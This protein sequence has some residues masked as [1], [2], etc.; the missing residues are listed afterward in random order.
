MSAAQNLW[1]SWV[2]YAKLHDV[3]RMGYLCCGVYGYTLDSVDVKQKDEEAAELSEQVI[4]Y[5]TETTDAHSGRMA[6]LF[7]DMMEWYPMYFV[8]IDKYT[9]LK[10]AIDHDIGEIAV[11]DVLDDH[12][13]AHEDKKMPEW[14]AIKRQYR[15]LP[16]SSR[17]ALVDCHHQFD[18]SKT[19]LGQS[20][21]LADKLDFLAG[22]IFERSKG[23]YG[24]V[25]LKT[26]VSKYDKLFAEEIGSNDYIDI[27]ARHL[28]QIFRDDQFDSRLQ[29]IAID[30]LTCGLKSIGRP[31]YPW[32]PK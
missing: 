1:D 4:K 22:L 18:E 5:N 2:N 13:Q 10:V 29:R 9:A 7:S 32:W 14:K 25:D 23:H 21:R 20:I 17:G 11:K 3:F 26:C 19:F 27:V 30:F 15:L 12:G 31:F 8:G 28:L 24:G 6:H 16:H